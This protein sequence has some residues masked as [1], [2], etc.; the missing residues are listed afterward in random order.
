MTTHSLFRLGALATLT[1]A[2]LLTVGKLMYFAGASST[3]AFVW[4]SIVEA[5]VRVFVL[6][7]AYAAQTRRGGAVSLLGFVITPLIV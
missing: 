3:L 1:T 5:M 4:I 2:L 6:I 7:V